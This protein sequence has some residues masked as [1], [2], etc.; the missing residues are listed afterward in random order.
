MFGSG[1]HAAS[2][3]DVIESTKKYTICGFISEDKKLGKNFLNYPVLSGINDTE[4]IFKITKNLIIAFGSIYDC[5]KRSK[6]FNSLRKKGFMF[7]TI[8][9]PNAYVSKNSKIGTGTI[10][11][12]GS[13]INS[14]VEIDENCIINSNSLIE[15]DCKL[16]SNC[17]VSTSATLNGGVVVGRDSFIG[18]RSVIKEGAILKNNTFIKMGQIVKKNL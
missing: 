13:V 14:G 4:K 1:G 18:S 11:M 12:H 17:H 2:C 3:A 15:H 8:V 10:V 16:S 9:S 6:I 5:K 7:H